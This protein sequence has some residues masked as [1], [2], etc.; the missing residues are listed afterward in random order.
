MMNFAHAGFF[1]NYTSFDGLNSTFAASKMNQ[2]TS[3]LDL[4]D[5]EMKDC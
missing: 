2:L 4:I 3:L 5:V 1:A